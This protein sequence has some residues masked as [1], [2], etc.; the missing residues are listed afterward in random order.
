[1]KRGRWSGISNGCSHLNGGC[2]E[3]CF[4]VQSRVKCSCRTGYELESDNTTCVDPPAFLIYS[5]KTDLHR[6]SLIKS[7][8]E[9]LLPLGKVKAPAAVETMGGGW[10]YWSDSKVRALLRGRVDGAGAG[11]GWE[12]VSKWSWI[13]K[14]I[15]KCA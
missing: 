15:N 10:V 14:I 11:G 7:E 4:W 3:L 12:K 5:G 1:M 2:S 13:L 6:V 8:S 9:E